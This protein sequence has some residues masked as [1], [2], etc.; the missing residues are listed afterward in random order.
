MA[1]LTTW[2]RKRPAFAGSWRNRYFVL[3]KEKGTFAEYANE[4]AATRENSVPIFFLELYS[5]LQ[6]ENLGEKAVRTNALL[7]MKENVY[8]M[9]ISD[10]D[11]VLITTASASKET[12]AKWTSAIEDIVKSS[13]K[14]LQS[15][16][17]SSASS[18]AGEAEK[19]P[20][21]KSA[22]PTLWGEDHQWKVVEVQDGVAIEGEKEFTRQF[23]SIRCKVEINSPPETVFALIMDD[24]KR[25]LWDPSVQ[26]SSV[27]REISPLSHIVYVQM[28]SIW[29]GPMHTDARDLVMLR[30]VSQDDGQYVITWQSVEEPELCPPKPGFVRGRV[31][32]MGMTISPLEGG[33]RSTVRFSCYADPGGNMSS[34]PHVVVQRWMLP[35]V[36][37]VLGLQKVLSQPGG[38]AMLHVDN[39]DTGVDQ[40]DDVAP[41]AKEPVS[42]AIKDQ[43]TTKFK[44]G[45]FPHD[46]WCET[47]QEE[48]FNVRGKT[49]LTDGIKK[50]SEAHKFHLVAAD[51]NQVAE[52]IR[53]CAARSDSPLRVIQKEFPGREIFVMQFMLPGPPHYSLPVY[54]VAKPGVLEDDSCFA[55]LYQA[56]LDGTDEYRNT[57]FKMIPRI[58]K[59]AFVVKRTVGETPAIM[60]KKINLHYFRGPGYIEI[61]V[62]LGTSAVAGSILSVFKGYATTI[63]A[64][65]MCLLLEGHSEDELPEEILASFRMIRP[66]LGQAHKLGPD[67]DP[68]ETKRLVD[69][70]E[71]SKRG[72]NRQGSTDFL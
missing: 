29:V 72:R 6:I 61:D 24:A 62:D 22:V 12:V 31:F 43:E 8:V 47:P 68:A 17:S 67:P 19:R 26:S 50:K 27:L 4:H 20:R 52:P 23:P 55:Q 71:S 25:S 3:D 36:S 42:H 45:T 51:L 44:V 14:T 2:M 1:P 70:V 35:F 39:V 48:A 58:T 53:H 40:D 7:P 28:R 30:Y 34:L 37:R 18:A 57:V 46:Q 49:Y 33:A 60:G 64:A 41:M 21:A 15:I 5:G 59:G 13:R 54:A 32:A 66:N 11:S 38:A 63:G 16:A 56:F 9:R 69:V 10:G 65:D